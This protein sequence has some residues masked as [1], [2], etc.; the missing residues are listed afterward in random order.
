MAEFMDV[1]FW[2]GFMIL[3]GSIS[4]YFSFTTHR[5]QA[6][7]K[8]KGLLTEAKMIEFSAEKATSDSTSVT[9]PVFT[10]SHKDQNGVKVFRVKGKTNSSA[11]IGE[12]TPIYY[13]PE[14]PEK[15]YYLPK[16]DFLMKYLM[17]F[18]GMFFC[19]LGLLYLLEDLN[20]QTGD[21]FLYLFIGLFAG[22]FVL[23]MAGRIS[24][25]VNKK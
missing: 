23:F 9:V 19:C 11:Q 1:Y 8:K 17:L 15:E 18:L 2:N 10:F 20:Y 22:T 24:Y 7:L 6:R 21:S 12:I 4:L 13:N 25:W 3:M 5:D 16:K 14:N